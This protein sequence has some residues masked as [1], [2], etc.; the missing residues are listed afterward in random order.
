MTKKQEAQRRIERR[1]EAYRKAEAVLERLQ[2][3]QLARLKAIRE[4]ATIIRQENRQRETEFAQVITD[5]RKQS[6]A[7][8]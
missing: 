4:D 5:L 3:R 1:L 8:A 2:K 6:A 7:A